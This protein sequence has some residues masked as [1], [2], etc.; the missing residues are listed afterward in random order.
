MARHK[1]RG[2]RSKTRID[3]LGRD[4]A[5]LLVR[6]DYLGFW[7]TSATETLAEDHGMENARGSAQ[8]KSC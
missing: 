4:F 2:R 8:G 6:E 3:P 7:P 1:A 5:V